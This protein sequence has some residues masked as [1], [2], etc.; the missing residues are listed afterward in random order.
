MSS[1][2]LASRLAVLKG[3]IVVVPGVVLICGGVL[4]GTPD[5]AIAAVVASV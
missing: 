5:A 2:L 1:V 4:D 3:G